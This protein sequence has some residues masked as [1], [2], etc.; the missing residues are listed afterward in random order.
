MCRLNFWY[1]K[2]DYNANGQPRYQL[3]TAKHEC[4]AHERVS[5]ET[6]N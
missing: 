2:V 6:P 5:T 1:I 3:C 4:D